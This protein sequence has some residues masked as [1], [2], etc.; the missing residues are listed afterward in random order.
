MQGVIDNNEDK[1]MENRYLYLR[2]KS[3]KI[4]KQTTTKKTENEK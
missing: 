2:Y 3:L 4:M 1:R